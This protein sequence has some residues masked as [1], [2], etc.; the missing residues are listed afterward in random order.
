MSDEKEEC[1]NHSNQSNEML[2][3][4]KDAK[5]MENVVKKSKG[6]FSLRKHVQGYEMPE[7]L[8]TKTTTYTFSE[9]ETNE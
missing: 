9:G 3:Q 1:K 6:K 7:R 5:R 2:Q 4:K 8:T